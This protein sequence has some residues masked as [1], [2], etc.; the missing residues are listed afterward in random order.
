MIVLHNRFLLQ[1]LRLKNR[2]AVSHRIGWL[3]AAVLTHFCTQRN[4]VYSS[5]TSWHSTQPAKVAWIPLLRSVEPHLQPDNVMGSRQLEAS[6]TCTGAESSKLEVCAKLRLQQS[7]IET[8]TKL[9]ACWTVEF[10]RGDLS[11]SV[12]GK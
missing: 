1:T 12:P 7:S 8:S 4:R 11:C 9:S 5:A 6:S 2:I 10:Y 3:G